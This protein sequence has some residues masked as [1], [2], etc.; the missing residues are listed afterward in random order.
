MYSI[1][2]ARGQS[3]TTRRNT[4]LQNFV[5]PIPAIIRDMEECNFSFFLTGSRFWG[6]THPNSDWDFFVDDSDGVRQWLHAHGFGLYKATS[7][8]AGDGQCN[9][10]YVLGDVIDGNNLVQIQVV[11]SATVKNTIQSELYRLHP[12][13]F[14]DKGQARAIWQTAFVMYELGCGV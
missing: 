14:S 2:A 6:N 4:M 3:N 11:K 5:L 10:V 9:A 12:S 1:T 13:G 8:Y 7:T